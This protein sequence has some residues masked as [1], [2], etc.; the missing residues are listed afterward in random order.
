MSSIELLITS[1]KHIILNA[2]ESLYIPPN[3]WHWIRSEK[4][5]AI[6]FWCLDEC[7]TFNEP[8]ILRDKFVNKD[9][10]VDKISNYNNSVMVWNSSNDKTNPGTMN[11][12]RD[13]NYVI[14]L[15]GYGN[16]KEKLNIPLLDH[17]KKDI[18]KPKYF[19]INKI[20]IF[21]ISY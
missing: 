4:S 12:N 19:K 3:W 11:I 6:N 18:M 16:T 2:G 10:I 13:N 7:T 17:V 21:L 14:T 9:L 8:H 20:S 5:I 15:P 1:P